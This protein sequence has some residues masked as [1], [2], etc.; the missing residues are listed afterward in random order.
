MINT[1]SLFILAPLAPLADS[2]RLGQGPNL[3]LETI[4]ECS[5]ASIETGTREVTSKSIPALRQAFTA[6]HQCAATFRNQLHLKACY[7]YLKICFAEIELYQR[8]GVEAAGCV[9]SAANKVRQEIAAA[10][11]AQA[12]MTACFDK[13]RW[14]AN[15][16]KNCCLAHPES[17]ITDCNKYRKLPMIGS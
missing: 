17:K 9:L 10:A 15:E 14:M 11:A 2:H 16:I 1:T 5:S 8:P 6:C 12:D 7:E 3:S 13:A 4:R